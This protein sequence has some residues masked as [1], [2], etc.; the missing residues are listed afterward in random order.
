MSESLLSI[1]KT[2]DTQH[3]SINKI[4][5]SF[6][7]ESC[8]RLPALRSSDLIKFDTETG[9]SIQKIVV[10]NENLFEMKSP[11][12]YLSKRLLT[13]IFFYTN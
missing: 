11:I 10:T 12:N 13:L 4:P 9:R 2:H 5:F 8:D 1:R 6:Y 3:H 7:N